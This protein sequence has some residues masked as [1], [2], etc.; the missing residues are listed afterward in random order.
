[1]QQQRFRGFA[2]DLF[3]VRIYYRKYAII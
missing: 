2:C 1:M 3:Y